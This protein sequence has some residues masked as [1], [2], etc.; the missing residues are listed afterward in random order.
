MVFELGLYIF[1]FFFLFVFKFRILTGV[2]YKSA[3]RLFIFFFLL[4]CLQHMRL[5]EKK[6]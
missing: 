6:F 2:M 1:L 3:F 5:S 4:F